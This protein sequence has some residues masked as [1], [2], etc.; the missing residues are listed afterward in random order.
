MNLTG[1]GRKWTWYNL[2]QYSRVYQ[3]ELKISIKNL[4]IVGIPDLNRLPG[5]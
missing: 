3:K 4:R 1:C 2:R 5:N